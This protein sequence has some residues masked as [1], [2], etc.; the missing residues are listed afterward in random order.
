M[1]PDHKPQKKLIFGTSGS[2]KS[3]LFR[4]LIQQ[5]GYKYVYVFDWDL[6]VCRELGWTAA[7]SVEGLCHLQD[8]GQPVVFYPRKLFP[9][10][11][12]AFSFFCRFVLSQAEGRKG[13]KLLCADEI[14]QYVT[15]NFYAMAPAFSEICNYGRN[16]EI[17][18]VLASQRVSCL[19]KDL[20]M[21]TT[22]LYVF[23]LLDADT[24][25]FEAVRE[26]GIDPEA[27]KRL[28]YPLQHRKVGWI[29]RNCVTGRMETVTH[30]IDPA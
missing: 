11:T 23:K 26:I 19:P 3:T 15:P 17:D 24:R 13:K 5:G 9:I 29:Y 6:K 14:Q 28:P 7:G 16:E 1:N 22:E 4:S 18:L 27:V 2:G 21:Q 12:E 20:L 10:L 8:T 30:A 25:G